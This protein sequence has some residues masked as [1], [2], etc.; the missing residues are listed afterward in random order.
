MKCVL[1][2]GIAPVAVTPHKSLNSSKGVVRN[3]ELARDRTLMKSKKNVPMIA[4][5]HR[6]V[7][8][9]NNVEIKTKILLY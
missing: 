5:V 4:D 3:W 6:I 7:V 2:G 8:K 1:F 9:K